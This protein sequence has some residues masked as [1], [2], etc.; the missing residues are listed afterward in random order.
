MEVTTAQL[1][2]YMGSLYAEVKALSEE[3]S[4]LRQKLM[5]AVKAV[6]EESRESE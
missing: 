1:F 4:L 3:N 6:V 5:E 2:Q